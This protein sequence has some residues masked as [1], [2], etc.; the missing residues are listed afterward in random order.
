M[1]HETALSA[2]PVP[3][4]IY[5]KWPSEIKITYPLRASISS[6]QFKTN[7]LRDRNFQQGQRSFVPYSRLRNRGWMGRTQSTPWAVC[8]SNPP[9]GAAIH[10]TNYGDFGN[11]KSKLCRPAVSGE[12]RSGVVYVDPKTPVLRSVVS[13]RQHSQN[14]FKLTIY[15][16]IFNLNKSCETAAL[17]AG[18]EIICL[19]RGHILFENLFVV[20][21]LFLLRASMTFITEQDCKRQHIYKSTRLS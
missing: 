18:S 16:R 7:N 9:F 6:F 2:S 4:W 19:S 11:P 3:N 13:F 20:S 21:F 15:R 17:K 10:S 8:S 5:C 12:E 1:D 14:D